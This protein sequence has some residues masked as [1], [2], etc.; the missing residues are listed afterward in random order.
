MLNREDITRDGIVELNKG[1]LPG[2]S[3]GLPLLTS[4]EFQAI[5]T[6][7]RPMDDAR[8]ELLAWAR[9]SVN[10]LLPVTPERKVVTILGPGEGLFDVP[11]CEIVCVN[12]KDIG[13]NFVEP[14]DRLM[15][16]L[17][18]RVSTS[19]SIGCASVCYETKKAQD[20]YPTSHSDLI[21]FSH[22]LYHL[23]DPMA[24]I[25][26]FQ[27]LLGK[28]GKLVIF[29]TSERSFISKIKNEFDEECRGIKRQFL[30]AAVIEAQLIRNNICYQRFEIGTAFDVSVCID[31]LGK[32]N[33]N[34][35]G[36][37]DLVNFLLGVK[38][39]PEILER[40]AVS[41]TSQMR[42]SDGIFYLL[43]PVAVFVIN[44]GD[45]KD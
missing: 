22:C 30:D 5:L 7:T 42:R 23:P 34:L 35:S 4:E 37:R 9:D 13:L 27:S 24:A 14:N 26:R 10:W 39:T 11:F 17:K 33:S 45:S 32:I 41:L 31:S 40:V 1:H 25:L 43:H 8:G 21:V 28:N 15:A 6:R 44:S 29:H 19:R 38:A 20:Y 12:Q 3:K 36:S 16:S 2:I 18:K